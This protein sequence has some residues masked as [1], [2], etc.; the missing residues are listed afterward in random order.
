MLTGT[1]ATTLEKK[2]FSFGIRP[3]IRIYPL[4]PN[5]SRPTFS[6]TKI[7]T[8]KIYGR[9]PGGVSAYKKENADIIVAIARNYH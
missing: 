8:L 4:L 5:V 9:I 3:Q 7:N 6:T 1:E 2:N